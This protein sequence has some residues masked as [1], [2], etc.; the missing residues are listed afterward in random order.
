MPK[1]FDVCV[2]KEF[3]PY[4]DRQ[5]IPKLGDNDKTPLP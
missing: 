5:N 2:G 1:Y 3:T 4:S